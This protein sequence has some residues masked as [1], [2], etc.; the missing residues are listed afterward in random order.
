V[1]QSPEDFGDKE[2]VTIKSPVPMQLQISIHTRQ[3]NYYRGLIH[4]ISNE[5]LLALEE[6]EKKFYRGKK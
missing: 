4:A 1:F 3:K 2:I 6:F 5:S